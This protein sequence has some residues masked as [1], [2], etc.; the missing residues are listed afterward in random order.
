MDC[1]GC[2]RG[3][4]THPWRCPVAVDLCAATLARSGGGDWRAVARGLACGAKRYSAEWEHWLD[5]A[6][7]P[8]PAT[9]P[10]RPWVL[11]SPGGV[12]ESRCEPV[13]VNYPEAGGVLESLK[14][15]AMADRLRAAFGPMTVCPFVFTPSTPV[16]RESDDR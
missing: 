13:G 14:P 3:D 10:T 6:E 7:Q 8:E 12:R 4:G 9:D 15:T 5:V 2:K 16:T 1:V 11:P